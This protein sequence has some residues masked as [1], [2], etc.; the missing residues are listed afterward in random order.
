[1]NE[2]GFIVPAIIAIIVVAVVGIGA[3]M[4]IS[5]Q[6][7]S[8]AIET[9]TEVEV[10]EDSAVEGE[11]SELTTETGTSLTGT[12]SDLIKK[13]QNMTCTFNHTDVNTSTSGTVYVA[14]QGQRMRGDFVVNQPNQPAMNAHVI[15]DTQFGY[16]WSDELPQGTKIAL[17]D[18]ATTP[19]QA[20]AQQDVLDEAIE[21]DCQSWSV[22]TSLFQPPANKEFIDISQQINSAAGAVPPQAQCASCNQLQ[23]PAKDQC[24]QALGC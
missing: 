9:A 11:E 10:G 13:G 16:F 12:V 2:R 22:D 20:S 14:S 23:G 7:E 19:E 24:L 6:N 15:R 5:R 4:Y 3:A 21:Y 17:T 1:M 8:T 18:E